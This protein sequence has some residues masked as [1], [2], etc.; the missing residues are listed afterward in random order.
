[1][2]STLR[3][4]VAGLTLAAAT[5]TLTTATAVAAPCRTCDD[6]GGG[7]GG[8]RPPLGTKR[9]HLQDDKPRSVVLRLVSVKAVDTEDV[10][11]ADELYLANALRIGTA[12]RQVTLPPTSLD[13]GQTLPLGQSVS[14]S[15]VR[16]N[17]QLS[18]LTHALDQ[19]FAQDWANYGPAISGIGGAVYAAALTIPVTAPFALAAAPYVA[20]AYVA[21]NAI[22][23]ADKDDVLADQRVDDFRVGDFPL[24]T[25]TK[26]VRVAN[27]AVPYWS[28]WDYT[29]TYQVEVTA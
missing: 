27:S 22:A 19:D 28:D 12:S 11:G 18:I 29:F 8:T 7:G 5:A 16:G 9:S 2:G 14:A 21:F 17:D 20:G 10:T 1:M 24:G 13:D 25:T 6:G 15:G 3:R 4:L 26:T 23:L